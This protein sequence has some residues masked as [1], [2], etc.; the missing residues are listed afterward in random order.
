MIQSRKKYFHNTGDVTL[1]EPNCV[2]YEYCREDR[3]IVTRLFDILSSAMMLCHI[4]LLVPHSLSEVSKL[5][6]FP[7]N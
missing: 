5:S 6:E 3:S 1:P 7:C 4:M 2:F